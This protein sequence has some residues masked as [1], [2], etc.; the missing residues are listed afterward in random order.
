MPLCVATHTST[1][2]ML[3]RNRQDVEFSQD[4]QALIV[5]YVNFGGSGQKN[6]VVKNKDA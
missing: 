1:I 5:E 6:N 2:Y 4:V 3:E